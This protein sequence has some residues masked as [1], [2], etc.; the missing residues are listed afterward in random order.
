MLM[1]MF[2]DV[3]YSLVAA[4]VFLSVVFCI[5]HY[6]KRYDLIDSAWGPTFLVIAL[7]LVARHGIINA[8]SLIVTVMVFIWA[9]RLASH[10]FVRF[11]RS[12]EEDRRYIELRKKWPKKYIAAQVFVRIYVVQALLA[13]LISL[14]VIFILS[15]GSTNIHLASIGMAVWLV[16]IVIESVADSQLKIFLS[17]PENRGR[18]MTDGLWGY[19][20]HPNYFGEV[21]LWWGIGIIGF[22]TVFMSLAF[23]GPVLLTLLI[24]FV[25]GVPPA[26]KNSSKKP[27]WK[28]YASKTNVLIP[29]P[30]NEE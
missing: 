30:P 20:R 14:P 3:L 15:N 2:A 22:T 16:G 7:A 1:Q 9:L 26:E 19:S 6:K 8:T 24:L 27:G 4:L 17:I 10:V 18:L 25:S 21:L 28:E 12:S 29:W 13:T 11:V 5:A 23:L